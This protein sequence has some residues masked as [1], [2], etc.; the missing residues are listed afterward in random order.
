MKA[1]KVLNLLVIALALTLVASGCRKRP[2]YL[3]TLPG[4]KT[5]KASDIGPG[6]SIPST[7]TQ[8][9]DMTS[10]QFTG[11]PQNSPESHQGWKENA[12][13]FK[14]NTVYF[15]FDSSAVRS[16]DQAQVAAVADYLKS[17]AEAA[18]RVEGN[19]DERG[20]E[21]YNRALGDRR[22]IAVRE[23]LIRLGIDSKRVDTLSYGEDKPA[24]T[25]SGEGVWSKNRR[26][27]F[28]L[29]TPP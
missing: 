27:E 25:G 12:E 20:T 14:A 16:A 10:D 9:T 15:A 28:I 21:E 5:Q 29:L 13:Q 8:G 2:T 6:E 4:S 18:V 24:V 1:Y 3:T 7:G 11:T 23:E 22:A 19:C 17:N 26:A